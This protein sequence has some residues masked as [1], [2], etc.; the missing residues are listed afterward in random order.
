M[1]QAYCDLTLPAY[2]SDIV[3]VGIQQGGIENA[4]PV[5][6]RAATLQQLEALMTPD[7]I[8]LAE[9]S[10]A[11]DADGNYALKSDADAEALNKMFPLPMVAASMHMFQAIEPMSP[12][13]SPASAG[14]IGIKVPMSPS[15]GPA[16]IRNRARSS[17]RS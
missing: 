13:A 1:T 9:A 16:F 11:L 12:E 14:P 2:T 4:V 8:K 17:S 6:L 3:N 15:I 7:E 5:K 10:Y